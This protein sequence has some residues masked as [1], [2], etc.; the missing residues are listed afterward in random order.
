MSNYSDLLNVDDLWEKKITFNEDRG[1][2]IFYCKDCEEIVEIDRK[3][4]N[5]YIF[6]CKKCGQTNIS[7]WTMAW[8]KENY[9]IK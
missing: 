8:I 3:N 6:I 9:R 7:I 1:D 5:S 4:P 2:I